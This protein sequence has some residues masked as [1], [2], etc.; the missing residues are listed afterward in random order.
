MMHTYVIRMSMWKEQKVDLALEIPSQP[1]LTFARARQEEENEI[2]KVWKR[3]RMNGERE[4]ERERKSSK[5][6]EERARCSYEFHK[7]ASLLRLLKTVEML[8][9]A[10]KEAGGEVRKVGTARSKERRKKKGKECES[11]RERESTKNRANLGPGHAREISAYGEI[12]PR[13]EISLRGEFRAHVK[14]RYG[15]ISILKVTAVH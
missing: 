14:I 10:E 9:P 13:R 12:T 15:V 1:F 8:L 4:R 7:R 5:A 11:W 2:K 6:W 3:K